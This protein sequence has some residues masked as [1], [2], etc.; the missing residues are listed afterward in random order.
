MNVRVRFAPS[1]TGS[2]HI[3]NIRT[4][5]FDWLFARHEGGVFVLRIEDTDKTREVPGSLEEIMRDLRWLGLQWDEGPEVGGP[6]GPYF[7][8]ERL[9]IYRKYAE[10]LLLRSGAGWRLRTFRGWCGLRCRRPARPATMTSCGGR[11]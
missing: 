10:Q 4:A 7:Q 3:G 9:D 1:P 8:S 6:Y 2:P 11:S 5:V